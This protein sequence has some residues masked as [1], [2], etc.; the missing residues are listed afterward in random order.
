MSETF[1]CDD[2]E[3]LV[4]YLYGEIDADG[5]REVERHLRT[6]AACTRETEALQSVRHDLQTWMPPAPDLG[7]TVVRATAAPAPVL[8]SPRWAAL[9]A[10]PAW[11]Q[12]AA[13]LLVLGV[14]AGVANL[15]VT[16]GDEGLVITTGWI[17][18]RPPAA[19]AAAAAPSASA[20]EWRL[21][22]AALEQSLRGEIAA[23]QEAIKVVSASRGGDAS[24][25]VSAL[26][27]RV[28]SMLDA[29]E[30]RQRQEMAYRLA[31][32][33]RSWNLRRQTDLMNINK[34]FGT[35]QGRTFAVQAGQQEMMN[36]LRRVNVSTTPPPN[37]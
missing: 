25:D 17:A 20:D 11:A 19:V 21:E 23:Q 13:A 4:A 34:S 30:T 26:L 35:L 36:Q 16:S 14:S 9:G 7:F 2:K 27:R 15:H 5:R 12:V 24:G 3:M 29:S 31:Q 10:L 22:L 8:T 33:E 1:R 32:A 37:Q 6:C 18:P 28:H